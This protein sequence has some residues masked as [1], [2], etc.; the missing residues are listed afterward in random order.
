MK[1]DILITHDANEKQV[2]IIEN[3]RLEEFYIERPDDYRMAVLCHAHVL[4]PTKSAVF[5]YRTENLH[6]DF[7]AWPEFWNM[8]RLIAQHY[9]LLETFI[10]EAFLQH[11]GVLLSFPARIN[12]QKIL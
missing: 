8:P 2:A 1:R 6:L 5:F 10:S 4:E 7:V 12:T 3:G 9:K 11:G